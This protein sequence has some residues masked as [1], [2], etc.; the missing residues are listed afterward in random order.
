MQ[1][2]H[3]LKGWTLTPS[4]GSNLTNRYC[5]MVPDGWMDDAKTIFLG[6]RLGID[7]VGGYKGPKLLQTSLFDLDLYLMMFCPSV[8]FE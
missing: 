5:D 6:L 1:Y 7:F 3:V 2:D 8:S 4:P